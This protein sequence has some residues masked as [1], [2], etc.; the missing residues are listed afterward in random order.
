M[1]TPSLM[2]HIPSA[3]VAVSIS[4]LTDIGHCTQF[5]SGGDGA[6]SFLTS[7]SC[8]I[9]SQPMTTQ[10]REGRTFL[11]PKEGLLWNAFNADTAAIV[12]EISFYISSFLCV[13]LCLVVFSVHQ[14][15][16]YYKNWSY[17]TKHEQQKKKRLLTKTT[18][19]IIITFVTV[20][21]FN[22]LQP[23]ILLGH[24]TGFGLHMALAILHVRKQGV[25]SSAELVLCLLI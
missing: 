2:E 15:V 7:P 5:A 16:I 20:V 18:L 25:E 13:G 23:N 3:A 19:I 9:L 8:T 11:I 1:S 14:K 10:R 6:R 4:H 21:V 22:A 24:I 12:L 17:D